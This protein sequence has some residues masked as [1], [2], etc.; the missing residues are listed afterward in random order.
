VEGDLAAYG[1]A[2]ERA[3]AFL[4]EVAPVIVDYAWQILEPVGDTE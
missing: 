1:W 3:D 2:A 4:P